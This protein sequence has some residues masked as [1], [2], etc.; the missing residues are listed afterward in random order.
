MTF[1]L[2]VC[3]ERQGGGIGYQLLSFEQFIPTNKAGKEEKYR[4][5]TALK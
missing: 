1:S 4:S 2:S 3:G 5:F